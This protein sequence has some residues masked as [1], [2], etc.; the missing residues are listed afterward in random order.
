MTDNDLIE[1]MA[2]KIREVEA[3]IMEPDIS[4]GN[5]AEII[6][7]DWDDWKDHATAALAAMRPE[8]DRRIAEA[9]NAALEEAAAI[10][11]RSVC[12]ACR[13]DNVIENEIRALK[14]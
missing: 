10:V 2:L 6:A 8:I 7:E 5:L 4:P 12:A 9:R 13:A 1:A 11:Q 3:K 14:S